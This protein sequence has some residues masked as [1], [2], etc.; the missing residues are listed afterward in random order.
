[1]F[2]VLGVI[3]ATIGG[4]QFLR[5]VNSHYSP[6]NVIGT[7]ANSSNFGVFLSIACTSASQLAFCGKQK[8]AARVV[9][10]AAALLMIII[11]IA[12]KTR[13]AIIVVVV[14]MVA[15]FIRKEGFWQYPYLS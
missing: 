5:V 7:L 1:M 14:A 11:L 10:G 12:S 6:H 15:P 2:I 13:T 8:L 3:E 4:F 9:F